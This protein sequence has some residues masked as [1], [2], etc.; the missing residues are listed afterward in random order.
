VMVVGFDNITSAELSRPRLSTVRRDY[1]EMNYHALERLIAKIDGRES[2]DFIPFEYEV[3]HS[4]S[5]GCH[6]GTRPDYFQDRYFQQTRL[7]KT[8][9][10]RQEQMAEQLFDATD[11]PELMDIVERN[12]GIFGCDNI[13]LCI[14]DY[15]YDNYDKKQWRQDSERFGRDMVLAACGHSD[16][17]PDE[18]HVYDRFPSR[19]L[20]P[21]SLMDEHR[22][23]MFYPLHYNTYSIGY[24]AMD[25]IS[26]AAKLNLHESIFSFLEIAIEN[27][28]KKGLLRQLN[29]V[30]DDLY[31]H[32]ALT[33]LYNRFGFERYARQRYDAFLERD[34][35]AQVLFVD[36]D[37]MKSINDRYGHDAGD[38][39][40]RATARVL[41]E[42]CDARD[43]L[44]RYGGDEFL[45]IASGKNE[46]LAQA[47]TRAVAELEPSEELPCALALSVGCAVSDGD[48]PEALDQ[49]VQRADAQMYDVKSRKRSTRHWPVRTGS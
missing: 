32:D 11:L 9:F 8:F 39:A 42:A 15:Y 5:C 34:G 13:F 2:R 1:A 30:L 10:T 44:M 23:L 19:F 7:L 43:F 45:V 18:R 48:A 33:G 47:I 29:A 3:I 21:G 25:G 27:V 16:R 41:R 31:V 49:C 22:F 12:Y 38:A 20:L 35:S 6:E 40:I 24:L 4:E 26:Q 37:D 46:G 17:R 28:R 14:N 36:M